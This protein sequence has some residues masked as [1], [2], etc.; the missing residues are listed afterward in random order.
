MKWFKH[1]T[2]DSNQDPL[3]TQLIETYGVAGYGH[4]QILLETIIRST[5]EFGI[6]PS[7]SLTIRRWAEVLRMKQKKAL[8][9]LKYLQNILLINLEHFSDVVRVEINNYQRLLSKDSVSSSKR[10]ASGAPREEKNKNEIIISQEAIDR[11]EL[12]RTNNPL[13]AAAAARAKR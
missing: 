4:Y 7:L 12:D 11:D 9:F 13:L 2:L 6:A 10:Q 5:E 1:H 8:S 3:I